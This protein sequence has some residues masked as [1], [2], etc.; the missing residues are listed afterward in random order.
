MNLSATGLL[1]E[2]DADVDLGRDLLVT[3]SVPGS[4]A[5]VRA[6]A[7]VMRRALDRG[8]AKWGVRFTSLDAAGRLALM[9]YVGRSAAER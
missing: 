9:E 4:H 7:R 8:A 1:L 6:E 3:F 5:R 2:T